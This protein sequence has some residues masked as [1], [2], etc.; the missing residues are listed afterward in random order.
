TLRS[1]MVAFRS[2]QVRPTGD[3]HNSDARVRNQIQ[4]VGSRI[5]R[6]VTHIAGDKSSGALLLPYRRCFAL[7]QS[8]LR[9]EGLI[10]R[11]LH[12]GH[13]T[14]QAL[15]VK[16]AGRVSRSEELVRDVE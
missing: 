7:D 2:H 16:P 14:L 1:K 13:S 11:R 8:L 4:A 3:A 10:E 6:I 12:C 9:S 15:R 5:F